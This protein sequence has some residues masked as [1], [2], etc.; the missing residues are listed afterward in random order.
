MHWNVLQFAY[1]QT[2]TAFTVGELALAR[3]TVIRITH[4]VSL[5]LP[6]KVRYKSGLSGASQWHTKSNPVRFTLPSP[7]KIYTARAKSLA[8]FWTSRMISETRSILDLS[9]SSENCENQTAS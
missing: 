1:F 7:F 3:V 6:R 9:P 5:A 4:A 2:S 8:R